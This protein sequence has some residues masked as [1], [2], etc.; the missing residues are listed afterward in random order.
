MATNQVNWAGNYTYRAGQIHQ[1]ETVDEVRRIVARAPKVHA[2]GSR[3]SFNH[4][5]DA[6]E[7]VSLARIA[8][9]VTIDPDAQTV[10]ASGA[11]RYGDLALVLEQAG[12]ALHNLASLPHISIAGAVATATHGSGD[13][14]GNLATAVAGLELVTSEGDLLQ[15][16]REDDRFPGMVVGLGALGVV[17]RLT[18]DVQPSYLVRQQVFEHLPW[19]VLIAEFDTVM[20]SAESVSVFTTYADIVEEIWLKSRVDPAQTAPPRADLLGQPVATRQLHPVNTLSAE[21][22]TGQLGV[23]GPWL[24]RL[25]HFRLDAVPAS[26]DELQTEFMVSRQNAIPALRALRE[27]A[28]RLQPHLMISELRSM[29]ADDLWMSMAYGVDTLGLHFSW[30]KDPAAV[31]RLLPDLEAALAP[32]APRPHWGKLFLTQAAEIQGRYER[33]RD[34]R[35]LAESLDPRGAFRNEFLERHLWG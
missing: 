24:H 29:A 13:R 7:L 5:A 2:L 26:G 1:P 21:N 27:I 18:L 9:E 33:F 8:P 25:P 15:V 20:A 14:N 16:T 17:T 23:P 31:A 11:M 4:I 30:S 10:T 6:P 12:W 32:F 22:C 28:P 19:D 34:F 3:H 35:Q